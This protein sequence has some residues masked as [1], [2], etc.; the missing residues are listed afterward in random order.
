MKIFAIAVM[1]ACAFAGCDKPAAVSSAPPA[2]GAALTSNDGTIATPACED[3][4]FAS[5]C[6]PA[7]CYHRKD[8]PRVHQLSRHAL[9][10]TMNDCPS[11]VDIVGKTRTCDEN[12]CGNHALG[13]IR[14]YEPGGEDGND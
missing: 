13:F 5:V 14:C 3:I 2:A 4:H 8:T 10:P 1:A 7:D 6:L 12:G 11:F 9:C